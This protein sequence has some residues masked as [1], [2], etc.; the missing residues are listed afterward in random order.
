MCPFLFLVSLLLI[1]VFVCLLNLI[2]NLGFYLEL[3]KIDDASGFKKEKLR[4]F[5]YHIW[6]QKFILMLA[7]LDLGN[8]F[9]TIAQRVHDD[10]VARWS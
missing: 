2:V 3:R 5:K 4:E 10:E 1:F 8:F 9:E 6:K 7:L